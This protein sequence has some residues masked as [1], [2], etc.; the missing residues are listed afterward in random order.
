MSRKWTV[1][2]DWI[3]DA[4]LRAVVLMGDRGTRCGYVGVANDHPLYG[5]EYSDAAPCLVFPSE[6]EIGKRGIVAVWASQGEARPD[7]VFDVHGG[8]TYSGGQADYP[9]QSEGLWWFG[10]DCA[11]AWDAASPEYLAEMR[12]QYPGQDYM[13]RVSD[14]QVHRSLAYC[15]TE[16]ESL[17]KQMVERPNKTEPTP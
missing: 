15:V 13:W 12:E 17:A 14:D 6:E 2:K 10:Y 11:H 9:A 5:C 3:T 1:E 7:A 8:L 4:G 16:C